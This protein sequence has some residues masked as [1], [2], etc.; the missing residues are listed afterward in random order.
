EFWKNIHLVEVQD[1]QDN[2]R[3]IK[4]V[5]KLF[6]ARTPVKF[7]EEHG[8][9]DCP[10][11]LAKKLPPSLIF[12]IAN[13]N[14]KTI[15]V[16]DSVSRMSD[17]AMAHALGS[18]GDMMFKKKEY[19]H[20]DNQGLLLK[21]VFTLAQYAKCHVVWISHEEELEHEDGTKKITP[22]AGTRNFS[23]SV[24]RYFDHVIY[25]QIL[26]RKYC[27]SSL[28]TSNIKVQAGNRNNLDIKSADD[29]L[30]IFS[31]KHI[32]EGK[33]SDFKFAHEDT[34]LK[35]EAEKKAP[36]S[37]IVPQET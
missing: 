16:I 2:P 21:S 32:L 19:S 9:I 28:G 6:K 33:T 14:T 8:D 12:D 34:E 4:V 31:V 15:V 7:C 36:T 30:N 25:T 29:F 27:I 20:Y 13:C 5:N 35:I 3:G 26:N 22:V 17:S 23:R 18:Q 10:L 37:Q 1:S 24:A 11:C